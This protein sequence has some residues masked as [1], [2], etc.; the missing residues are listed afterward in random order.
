MIAGNQQRAEAWLR[1]EAKKAPIVRR[2][3]TA[4]GIGEIRA[5]QIAAVVVT[6]F[7]FRTKRQFWSYCGLA[8]VTEV[9]SEWK[10]D[11]R[12]RWVRQKTPLPRGLNHNRHSLLKSVFKGPAMT[13]TQTTGEPLHQAYNQLL[14]NGT[15][16]NLARLTIARRIAAAVLAMWKN[17]EDYDPT[18]HQRT[19]TG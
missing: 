15:K 12:G 2:L 4:P 9:S 17:Q 3:A 6:P 19:V 5:A 13:V 7:R 18:R 10:R 8:V 16:P 1:E 14:Q 11:E